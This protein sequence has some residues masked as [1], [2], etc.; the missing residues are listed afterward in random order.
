MKK[1]I[2][3]LLL[4]IF[5][6]P[7]TLAQKVT[8]VSAYQEGT[9]II[10][11]YDLNINANIRV[12]VE[13]PSHSY[14]ELKAVTGDVGTKILAGSNKQIKWRPLE[15]RDDFMAQKVR[16]K[17]EASPFYYFSV[18]DTKKITFSPGNLQYHTRTKTWHFAD[19]QYKYMG[20][21]N[22]VG[23]S[24]YVGKYGPIV[25][26][27]D[28]GDTIDTFGASR[29]NAI[30]KW[31]I[32]TSEEDSDYDYYDD[33]HGCSF[34]DWGINKIGVDT[35]Y[36]WRSMTEKE[37]KYLI[38]SRTNASR[39]LFFCTIDNIKGLLILP[40][41]WETP[42]GIILNNDTIEDRFFNQN[43]YSIEQ[44]NI[45]EQYGAVFLPAAGGKIGKK[46]YLKMQNNDNFGMGAYHLKGSIGYSWFLE[47]TN[48]ELPDIS[49]DR[50]GAS[51]F[52]V[53]LV[54]DL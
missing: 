10:I 21:R 54:R 44:W 48:Y 25:K 28:L 36:V 17:V 20:Y 43:Y 26:Y 29:R 8:K 16:F 38:H 5:G 49:A 2:I 27:G 39:L 42:S 18:G 1:Y 6:I 11:T 3:V 15:E 41:N 37:G 14:T 24:M 12:Y 50:H 52:S 53:R 35:S 34:Q 33:N 51:C 4:S 31:G 19:A 30:A 46:Y 7:N 40:D 47:F 22:I 9:D 23:D 13:Y 45:M 32:S